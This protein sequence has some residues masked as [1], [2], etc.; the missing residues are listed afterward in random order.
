[1]PLQLVGRGCGAGSCGRAPV[2]GRSSCALMLSLSRDQQVGP[3]L[4][5]KCKLPDSPALQQEVS[6]FS[7]CRDSNRQ[8]GDS[9]VGL[10]TPPGDA[11]NRSRLQ[12][13]PD[14]RLSPGISWLPDSQANSPCVPETRGHVVGTCAGDGGGRDRGATGVKIKETSTV[15]TPSLRRGTEPEP[16]VA[17]SGRHLYTWP[18]FDKMALW[19]FRF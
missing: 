16:R 4:R 9:H 19:W 5:V 12:G 13:G 8:A 7:V 2:T 10:H 18:D 11:P 6:H 15:W 14:H 17:R 1:M 3:W